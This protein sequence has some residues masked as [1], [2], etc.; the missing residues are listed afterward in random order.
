MF[1]DIKKN[2]ATSEQGSGNYLNGPEPLDGQDSRKY[3]YLGFFIFCF[4]LLVIIGGAYYIFS[5]QLQNKTAKQLSNVKQTITAGTSQPTGGLPIDIN[6]A[7]STN[8][9]GNTLPSNIKTEDLTFGYFYEPEIDDFKV[10]IKSYQLPINIKKDVSNYYAVA[11]AVNLDPYVSD[12][13]Q[14]G[15]AVINNANPKEA[16]D[17]YSSYRWLANKQIPLVF[18][19]DFIL[20][21]YQN[22]LKQ[23][24]KEIEKTTFFENI[25]DVSNNL[26]QIS[27]AR[28]K[29]KK[30]QVGLANDPVLEAERLECAYFATALR[31]LSPLKEQISISGTTNDESLFDEAEAQKYYFE[32]PDFLKEDVEKE[33]SLIKGVQKRKV[34]SPLFL[35]ERSYE[36]FAVP[37]EYNR[38]AKLKNYYLALKWFNSLFPLHYQSA[39]CPNCLLDFD[40]WKINFIAANLIAN[41]LYGNQDLINK[42]AIIYK[43][44]AFFSGLRMDL[45]YLHYQEVLVKIYGSDKKADEIFTNIESDDEY[46]K[47]QDEL[48]NLQFASPEGGISRSKENLPIIGLRFLQESYWPNDYIF[49][50][51]AG[52]TLKPIIQYGAANKATYCSTGSAA[53]QRCSG[54]SYDIANL[55]YPQ[56]L[57]LQNKY[58]IAN[59]NYENYDAS[60][61]DLKTEIGKFNVN[62]WNSNVY[63]ITLEINKLVANY[64]PSQFPIYS[65]NQIWQEERNV[66]TILG[67]WADI[68]LP[69]ENVYDYYEKENSRLGGYPECN[70]LSYIEPNIKIIDEIIAKNK[71]LIKMLN[72]LNMTS[73]NNIA[74]VELINLNN[75]FAKL[76]EIT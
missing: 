60:L 13:N 46:I 16:S 40:D 4:L 48:V 53:G 61:A 50:R 65:R 71:M 67:A 36:T 21:F 24:Y 2:Q 31:L 44:I 5:K 33:I 55:I 42:W 14:N 6:P 30:E 25:W 54:F 1:I 75:K 68:N 62:S 38:N 47:L 32:L 17:F 74:S 22:N 69:G 37:A 19:S 10:E 45:T 59:V 12:F 23:I 72:A 51:L 29:K 56:E 18:T 9:D 7:S 63:W 52:P 34:K 76:V 20:Y 3:L 27:L 28:Y 57:D 70:N 73:K 43:F 15:F 8:Q 64:D 26:Y 49:G 35:Y 39:D 66:N 58:Y 41:D 11:R